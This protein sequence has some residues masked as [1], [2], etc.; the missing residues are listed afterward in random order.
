MTDEGANWV[1]VAAAV[2][3]ERESGTPVTVGD[4][5]GEL[6]QGSGS[7][8]L[9]VHRPGFTFR[10]TTS[11]QGPLSRDDLIRFAAGITRS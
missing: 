10:V 3:A 5:P 4:D 6:I 9:V 7:V 8:T 1:C 2:V 11:Q